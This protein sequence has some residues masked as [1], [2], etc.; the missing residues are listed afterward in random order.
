MLT[1]DA[2]RFF[3]SKPKMA[4]AAGVKPPSVYKWGMLVPEG[5]AARLEAASNG[6]LHYD[7]NM[8]DQYRNDKRT[9]EVNHENQA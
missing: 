9:G 5:R 7:K 2:L 3:G 6:Q 1:K 8:Y 4:L